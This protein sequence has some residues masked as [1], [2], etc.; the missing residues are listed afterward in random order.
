MGVG[1][2]CESFTRDEQRFKLGGEGV[3][4]GRYRPISTVN[5]TKIKEN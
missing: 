3:V 2:I 5:I 1:K 4:E